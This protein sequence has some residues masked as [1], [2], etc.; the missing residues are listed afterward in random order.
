MSDDA[1]KLP[2]DVPE[3][4]DDGAGFENLMQGRDAWWYFLE[5]KGRG[6]LAPE[7]GSDEEVELELA[8]VG[9]IAQRHERER[10]PKFQPHSTQ[11]LRCEHCAAQVPADL[12]FCVYCGG[13][14]RFSHRAR[15]QL[16]I[17]DRV[18]QS[19]VLEELTEILKA[20]ND[21]LEL[22]E[23]R[24][25]LGQPPAVFYFEGRDEHA[26]ALVDRLGELGVRARTSTADDPQ[27][28]MNREVAE[29]ILRDPRAMG[30]WLF[31]VT[32]VA[33]L[34]F[35]IPVPIAMLIG[36][37]MALGLV[38]FQSGK[39][40]E[41]YELDVVRVLNA[42]TGMDQAMIQAARKALASVQ[43][44]E[45]KQTLTV[46]LME[47]YA[48]WRQL[49]A[50][51]PQV[52]QMLGGVKDDL[53]DLLAQIIDTCLQFAE[54]H[55]YASTYPAEEVRAEIA[56]LDARFVRSQDA[57]ERGALGRQLEQRHKQLLVIEEVASKIGP[58]RARLG[59]MCASMESLRARVVSMSLANKVSR[60]DEALVSEIM[61][62]LD[63]ELT[64]FEE[65]VAEVELHLE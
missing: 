16:L 52:R 46:C 23:V 11:S 54:L 29:S 58:F 14:P 20:S 38:W 63:E 30:M 35:I 42:L 7:L 6:E 10:R 18:E 13:E 2:V 65:A 40:R 1:E 34:G 41:R 33:A 37:S 50:A 31:A 62:G 4:G 47:Y 36:L 22:R 25:A 8:E 32:G 5:A 49:S 45:V 44:E 3:Q 12:T 57:R 24:H 21:K 15:W 27:V 28:S 48:I 26:G 39:Y 53:D 43:D 17:V 60:D 19:E 51:A 9:R 59:A 64:V 56:R 61:L 55:N